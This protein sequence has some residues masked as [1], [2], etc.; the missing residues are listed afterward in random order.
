MGVPGRDG[1]SNNNLYMQNKKLT[2]LRK[3]YWKGIS[4][5]DRSKIMSVR[6]KARWAKTSKKDRI[7]YS[8]MMNAVRT[9]K[10]NN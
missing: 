6:V 1:D 5:E 3:E 4:K 10:K 8:Q 9:S 7:A 2:K